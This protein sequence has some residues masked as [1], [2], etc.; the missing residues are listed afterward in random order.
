V[1][2][3]YHRYEREQQFH[4]HAFEHEVRERVADFYQLLHSCEADYHDI[5]RRYGREAR[6]LEYGCGTGSSSFSL[7]ADGARV[8]AI[9]LSKTGIAKANT[10][11]RSRG[12]SIDFRVMNAERLDFPANSFD[13]VCG[14]GIL[15]H[16]DLNQALREVA[17]V[18]APTGVAAFI[19]PLGDNPAINAYRRR[20]PELRT[21]DEHPLLAEDLRLA[22]NFFECVDVTYYGLLTLASLP[23]RR[24]S[25]FLSVQRMLERVD[26]LLLA[27][28][29]P[30]RRFAWCCLLVLHNPLTL[31]SVREP[32]DHSSS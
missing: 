24:A 26:R 31:P 32:T 2:E 11:A 23:L 10:E 17:R 7:A 12:L 30:V 13:L 3:E 4:D 28:I 16:L 29:P 15:H 6:V 1:T 20:T 9:D 21:P 25:W 18:L 14:S 27:K 8:T 5:L 19:E 22:N